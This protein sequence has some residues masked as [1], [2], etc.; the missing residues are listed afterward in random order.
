[1]ELK[2]ELSGD[3]WRPEM[4]ITP[5]FVQE[6]VAHWIAECRLMIDQTRLLTLHAARAMDVHGSRVARKQVSS[7]FL[8]FG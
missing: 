1:M 2:S 7:K 6:V 4:R 8:L 3:L 5:C